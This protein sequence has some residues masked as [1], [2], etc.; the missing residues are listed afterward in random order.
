MLYIVGK[1]FS[2]WIISEENGFHAS[3]CAWILNF[4]I[5]MSTGGYNKLLSGLT[6][7]LCIQNPMAKIVS[8]IFNDTWQP[9]LP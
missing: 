6:N 3:D 4:C 5:Y 2:L 1:I 9:T 7:L 8:Q